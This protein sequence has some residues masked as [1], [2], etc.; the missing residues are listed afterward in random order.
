MLFL[1]FAGIWLWAAWD[2]ASRRDWL[3]EN[4]IVFVFVPVTLWYGWKYKLSNISYTFITIYLCLHAIGAH[5]MYSHV[6][7]GFTLG[8]W[9]GTDRNMYDRLLHFAFGLCLYLPIREVVMRATNVAKGFW[10]YF[11]P[12]CIVCACAASY[13]IGEW[14]VADH[15]S[16]RTASEF[17]AAQ[18]D[19]WDSQKDMLLAAEG[20]ILMWL[21]SAIRSATRSA[22]R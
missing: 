11:L 17:L 3:L 15:T 13:E 16:I 5:Y 7:F 2:P 4:G 14:F 20:S 10:S 6:P 19:P 22:Y 18:G 21:A 12:F 9:A 1:M 8:S